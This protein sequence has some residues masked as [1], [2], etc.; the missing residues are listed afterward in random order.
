GGWL[1]SRS[2]ASERERLEQNL[3]QKTREITI[4]IDREIGATRSLLTV[5]A[6][7]PFL[8]SG[9]VGAVHPRAAPGSG[10][11][12]GPVVVADPQLNRQVFNTAFPWGSPIVAQTTRGLAVRTDADRK[13]L[14]NGQTIVTDVFFGPLIKRHLVA[15][16]A[17]VMRDGETR[18]LLSIGIPTEKFA[19]ILAP[20]QLDPDLLAAVMDRSNVIVARSR[21]HEEF[22]GRQLLVEPTGGRGGTTGSTSSVNREGIAYHWVWRRSP[23]TGW[24]VSIG[25]PKDVLNAPSKIA[26]A[27]YAAAGLLLFFGAAAAYRIGGRVSQ[28]I[29]AL[30]SAAVTERRRADA[31]FQTLV[32]SAPNG[33]IAVDAD[34]RIVLVNAQTERMF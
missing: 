30:Q 20:S 10:Q 18:Y 5:L 32:E 27:S 24:L 31:Q 12:N 29:G 34:G 23:S 13:A 11:P 7:S 8:Y 4:A 26:L 22:S 3:Y 1:A 9:E 2:A 17:P 19:E 14:N 15:V 33:V 21:R 6:T 25:V 16:I 28:Q